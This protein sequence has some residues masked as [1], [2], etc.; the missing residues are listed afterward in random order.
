MRQ[1]RHPIPA[2]IA[3]EARQGSIDLTLP[4]Y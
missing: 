3:A 2:Y 4:K 1:M